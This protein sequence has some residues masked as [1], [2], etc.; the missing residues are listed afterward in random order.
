LAISKE[1]KQELVA[2][3]KELVGDS[4]ALIMTSYSGVSVKALEAVRRNI[5][6]M[7][8]EFHIVKNT[9]FA[10]VM[11]EVGYSLPKDSLIGTTAI[12]FASEEVPGVAKAIVDLAREIETVKIKGGLIDKVAYDAAQ[13][14]TLADLPPLPFIQGQLLSILQA[15]AGKIAMTLAGSVRQLVNVTKAYAE[16]DGETAA[17][18][19]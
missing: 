9:L 3:Y 4:S 16:A 13:I 18:P 5:R 10:L 19:A 11:D 6:E 12:G 1:K 2:F 17:V 14:V 15:P 7:G 8:G